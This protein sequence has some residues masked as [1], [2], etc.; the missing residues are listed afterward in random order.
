MLEKLYC[1]R[2]ILHSGSKESI[3][4]TDYFFSHLYHSFITLVDLIYAFNKYLLF[5]NIAWCIVTIKCKKN[6]NQKSPLGEI[7]RV[8]RVMHDHKADSGRECSSPPIP[9]NRL[10]NQ[11][12]SLLILA[13]VAINMIKHLIK[14]RFLRCSNAKVG[15][16][17]F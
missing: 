6:K 1:D 5:C 9:P 16:Q 4:Y 11:R 10:T 7:G 12:L 14:F 2:G 3:M 8:F 17:G 15:H 13:H